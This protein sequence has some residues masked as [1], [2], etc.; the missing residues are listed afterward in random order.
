M[1]HTHEVVIARG[2]LCMTNEGIG[3]RRTLCRQC[4]SRNNWK[5]PTMLRLLN[6]LAVLGLLLCA[7]TPQA[8][9]TT[10]YV[11]KSGDDSNTGTSRLHAFAT[12][13]KAVETATLLDRI[14]VGAGTY[15]ES[16]RKT[17]AIGGI[18]FLQLRADTRGLFTGDKGTVRL[19]PPP[20]TWA[21]NV[22]NLTGLLISDF[23]IS[24]TAATE[25]SYGIYARDLSSILY[26]SN[27]KFKA[28]HQGINTLNTTS[29]I[30][31]NCSFDD[32]QI[33]MLNNQATY[34]S[35]SG[36]KF[37]G[38]RQSLAFNDVK[39]AVANNS[40][41]GMTSTTTSHLPIRATRCG[42]YVVSST[43]DDPTHAIYATDL[44]LCAITNVTINRPR[45]YGIYAT[46]IKLAL[47]NV[48]V[49]GDSERIGY[50]VALTDTS[51]VRPTLTNVTASGLYCGIMARESNYTCVNVKSNDNVLGLYLHASTPTYTFDTTSQVHVTD[52]IYGIYYPCSESA[53]G[54]LTITEANIQDNNIGLYTRNANVQMSKCHFSRN[55]AGANLTGAQEVQVSNCIFSDNTARSGSHYGLAIQSEET[56]V[57]DSIFSRSYTGLQLT[58]LGTQSPKLKRLTIADNEYMGLRVT[59]GR[60]ELDASS[61]VSI[62]GSRYGVYCS[63]VASVFSNIPAPTSCLYTLAHVYGS[64]DIRDVA[65]GEGTFGIYS[66]QQDALSL[67]NITLSGTTSSGLYANACGKMMLSSVVA[68]DNKSFGLQI[69]SPQFLQLDRIEASH[70]GTY[71]LYCT[72]DSATNETFSISN[73]TF[74]DNSYGFRGTGVPF[75]PQTATNVR[76]VGNNQALRIENAPLELN[77]DMQIAFS[78]NNYA[79][80]SYNSSLTAS[81]IEMQDNQIG[82]YCIGGPLHIDNSS[83]S[84][85][86]YAIMCYAGG[87]SIKNCSILDANYGIYFSPR[88]PDAT[89]LTVT[90]TRIRGVQRIG[91]YANT[92]DPITSAVHISDC[93]V[94]QGSYG[95]YCNNSNMD[96]TRS[97]ISDS[98]SYGVYQRAGICALQDVAINGAGSWGI[99]SYGKSLS[100]VRTQ[101]SS[102]NG[103]YLKVE[104]ARVLNSVVKN[105]VY[106]IYT[107]SPGGNINVTQSTIGNVSHYGLYHNDGNLSITNS[108]IDSNRYG[109]YNRNADQHI[110][111][112]Y[113]LVHAPTAN[114]VNTS[115]NANEI[116][117]QPIFLNRAA[118]DLHLDAGSPAINAGQ[119]LS[120]ST[121]SDIEGN[122]RPSFGQFEMGA[123]E[124]MQNGGSLRVL[125]WAELAND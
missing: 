89:A 96:V 62:S 79:A 28:L 26:A 97:Q 6:P 78:G 74:Q 115:A 10:Y 18:V 87:S 48:V 16:I 54:Q 56:Q 118:G 45:G 119:D 103:V 111:H 38:C 12:I 104:A 39:T 2:Q 32:V 124:Y 63:E 29:C 92:S 25:N 52:N 120:A 84:A 7:L 53:L 80:M 110:A 21:L 73:S 76:F 77:P 5:L 61:Q 102:Q 105:S 20:R 4:L 59:N 8:F 60:L 14:F 47:L 50:G 36:C 69:R 44:S 86:N 33:A 15:Q 108:I 121:V 46:G 113:N 55:A 99:L 51:G 98:S 90:D 85:A 68:K 72:S 116:Q 24:T 37:S 125:N 107:N 43:F 66:S 94:S 100:L 22:S 95:I 30:A 71:G 27:C 3:T 35:A 91:L 82:L 93:D 13:G 70:N 23:E 19:E 40:T 117:K 83:V 123:Y 17:N 58:N 101:V 75:T 122:P 31:L 42:L 34:S 65:I 106:G 114:F 109:L 11:R 112:D 9:A 88:S 1:R 41:F 67:T 64:L 57:A 49:Q 81:G